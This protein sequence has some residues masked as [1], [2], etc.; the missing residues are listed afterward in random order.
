MHSPPSRRMFGA[1]VISAFTAVGLTGSASAA[2][3]GNPLGRGTQV[4]VGADDDNLANTTI[5]PPGVA[6]NQSLRNAD[7]QYGGLGADTLVGRQGPD[8]QLGGPGDDVIVGGTEGGT[9]VAAFPPSDVAHGGE[10]DDVFMWAPGDGSDAFVGGEPPRYTRVTRNRILRRGGRRV[11]VRVDLRVRSRPDTD[12]LVIG[13]L[14]LDPNDNFRP[15]LFARRWGRAPLSNVSDR[16]L[17]AQV[18]TNPPRNT[19]RGFCE[20]VPAP[21]GSAYQFLVRFL[22]DAGV[23]AVTIRTHGVE[24][25]LCGTRNAEGITQTSLGADGGGPVVVRSTDFSPRAGSKIDALVD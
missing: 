25:V 22:N 19:V 15:Q 2:V 13:T 23:Q 16:G 24:E 20:I 18:G 7:L 21:A 5:Q 3:Q 17:P 4:L 1:V 8:V 10:G 9:D 12:T 6:A 14:L 11:R